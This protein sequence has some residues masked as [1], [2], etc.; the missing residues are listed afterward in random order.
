MTRARAGALLKIARWPFGGWL[1]GLAVE[2]WA[3]RLPVDAIYLDERVIAFRHPAPEYESH[4][5]IVPRKR[6]ATL[7]EFSRPGN[8]AYLGDILRATH[9]VLRELGLWFDYVMLLANGGPRQEV[10]QA[11]FHLAVGEPLVI[12][13]PGEAPLETILSTPGALVAK[14]P[15]PTRETHLLI[16]P[17]R[18]VSLTAALSRPPLADLAAMIGA[19]PEL[20]QRFSLE[21]RGYAVCI[22]G[23]SEAERRRLT[24][25]V[26]AGSRL[27]G[28]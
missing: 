21:R 24:M 14:H 6:I 27:G 15:F 28:G 1:V 22:Q 9:E 8:A 19:L 26:I 23:R 18:A 7:L 4:V 12:A 3:A 25:H 13:V 20:D 11:H 17:R 10:R 16:Q 2:R 5:L